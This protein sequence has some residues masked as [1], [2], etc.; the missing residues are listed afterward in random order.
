MSMMVWMGGFGG[1]LRRH[2]ERSLLSQHEQ[3]AVETVPHFERPRRSWPIEHAAFLDQREDSINFGNFYFDM[4]GYPD[5]QE[6]YQFSG[7]L[8]G[9][10]HNRAGGFSFADGHTDIKRWVD[11]LTTPPLIR[12]QRR[13]INYIY[14]SPHNPDIRWLQHRAT[15][16]MN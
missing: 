15:R 16:K 4:T 12:G 14:K 8:P 9:S 1:T 10:Y 11:P 2:P 5:K 3:P 6:Q 13:P 7:D